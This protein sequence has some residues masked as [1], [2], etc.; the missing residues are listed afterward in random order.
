MK[1]LFISLF[2]FVILFSGCQ[3][4]EQKDFYG[5]WVWENGGSKMTYVISERT[6]SSTFNGPLFSRNTGAEILSWRKI[7]NE[8][9]STMTN[10]PT[11]SEIELKYHGETALERLFIHQDKMS[12][13]NS[14]EPNYIYLK[15]SGF[16]TENKSP[17]TDTNSHNNNNSE[18][19]MTYDKVK[20]GT[21]SLDV[22]REYN[23]DRKKLL[24]GGEGISAI[25]QEN[26]SEQIS[27]RIFNFYNDR[28]MNV[29]VYYNDMVKLEYLLNTLTEKYGA[30]SLP[31]NNGKYT[32][33]T[34][35]KYLPKIS[36]DVQINNDNKNISVGYSWEEYFNKW[37]EA[38]EKT[39]EV[40]L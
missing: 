25:R 34:Y 3:A 17:I 8:D 20:F 12:L 31:T 35:D 7:S 23:L 11:G 36:V 10:Y 37:K 14:V 15:Q 32:S 33:I 2:V 30:A 38:Y 9:V 28:L 6:F 16:S 18:I 4:Q 1:K 21:R 40:E 39:Q 24:N 27:S 19:I 5:T 26:P 13:I 29:F 22:I